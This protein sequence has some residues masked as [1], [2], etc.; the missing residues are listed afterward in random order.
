MRA[1]APTAYIGIDE[2]TVADEFVFHVTT[3]S[4]S[5]GDL[6]SNVTETAPGWAEVASA[7][8]DVTST[9]VTAGFRQPAGTEIDIVSVD[10]LTGN[11][12]VLEAAI[13]VHGIQ[14]CEGALFPGP[15]GAADGVFFFLTIDG[16][17]ETLVAYDMAKHAFHEV[18]LPNVD[19][20]VTGYS[21]ITAF[22]PPGVPPLLA[23]LVYNG[24]AIGPTEVVLFDPSAPVANVTRVA[25]AP[26]FCYIPAQ[27]APA[28]D[29]STSTFFFLLLHFQPLPGGK[30]AYGNGAP[31][32]PVLV[33]VNLARGGWSEVNIT[34]VTV[35]SNSYELPLVSLDWTR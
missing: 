30:C 11:A 2:A 35:P 27:S 5:T 12:S 9:Y 32:T 26:D 7:W 21:G 20:I 23:A 28:I 10:A 33:E 34:G 14:V 24:I 29:A 25:R 13:P 4:V 15:S 22:A 3:I 31:A 6:L 18:P 19:G 17:T 1:A 8:D 16:V